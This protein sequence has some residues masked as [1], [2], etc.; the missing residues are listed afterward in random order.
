MAW[1][2]WTDDYPYNPKALRVGL[3][4]IGFD[5]AGVCWCNK[6][7]LDGF[8]PEADISLVYPP[9]RNARK[10]AAELVAVDRWHRTD[11]L[12]SA[13]IKVY[14]PRNLGPGWVIHDFFDFNFSAAEIAERRAKRAE[15]GRKGGKVSKPPSTA[16]S[17][18]LSDMQANAQAN[19]EAPREAPPN[20]V[21]R[22]PLTQV[23]DGS[24]SPKTALVHR[25]N[26]ACG[27]PNLEESLKVVELLA[28]HIDLNLLDQC[29]GW[30]CHPN[31]KAAPQHPRYFLKVA[32]DWGRQRGVEIP[33]LQIGGAR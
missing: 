25:L 15:A 1:G 8:I 21:S 23:G 7:S 24:K 19:G 33:Q 29:I 14:G 13:C 26:N 17:K 10:L 32:A 30:A 20:P 27:E 2:K 4:C 22:I 9:A 12:C 18:R 5:V 3:E 31:S 6:Q 28:E 11:A 16:P